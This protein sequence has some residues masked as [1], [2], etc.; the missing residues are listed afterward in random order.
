MALKIVYRN[1]RRPDETGMKIV[2]DE[3]RAKA[4][5]KA[6]E[7]LGFI[8]ISITTVPSNGHRPQYDQGAEADSLNLPLGQID[9]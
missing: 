2:P 5:K 1:P 6:L 9:L 4:E 8:V 7:D 3:L